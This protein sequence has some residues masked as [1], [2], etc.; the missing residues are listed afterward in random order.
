MVK[1][2]RI[3]ITEVKRLY[4]CQ[5]E[6]VGVYDTY[7]HHQENEFTEQTFLLVVGVPR[8]VGGLQSRTL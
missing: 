5:E 2:V 4:H 8:R 7:G 3:H 1:K 6:F